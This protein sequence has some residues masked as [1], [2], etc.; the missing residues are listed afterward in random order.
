MKS[1]L[2]T[3]S[4]CAVLCLPVLAQEPP[5]KVDPAITQG[6]ELTKLFYRGELSQVYKQF[7]DEMRQ[8]MTME[9]F[10]QSRRQVRRLLEEEDFHV[11]TVRS[12]YK[13]LTP[14][15]AA[16]NL[17][18]FNAG[19]GRVATTLVGALPTAIAARPIP[20]YVGEMMVFAEPR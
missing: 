13:M 5:E 4:L 14:R 15:Y 2:F 20:M 6:R 19:L 9:Q 10:R 12:A 18:N 11:E 3:L 17:R 1:A 7:T 16:A 8:N